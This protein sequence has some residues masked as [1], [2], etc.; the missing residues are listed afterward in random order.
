MCEFIERVML[1]YSSMV[2]NDLSRTKRDT[3]FHNKFHVELTDV[4]I[5]KTFTNE[6]CIET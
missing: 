2:N 4:S 1:M 6:F 3:F 5:L